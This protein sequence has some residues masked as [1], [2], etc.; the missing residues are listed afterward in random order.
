MDD[1]SGEGDTGEVRWSW[2]YDESGRGRSKCGWQSEWGSWFQ[3]CG[4]AGM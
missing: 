2:K 4:D 1:Y 3:R